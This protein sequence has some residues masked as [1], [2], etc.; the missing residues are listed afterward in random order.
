MQEDIKIIKYDA[1]I[2][3]LILPRLKPHKMRRAR[4]SVLM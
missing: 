3:P 1:K 4:R 2:V